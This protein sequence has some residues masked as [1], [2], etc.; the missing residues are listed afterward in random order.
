MTNYTNV[1][2][3][4]LKT[5][6]ELTSDYQLA[7]LLDVGTSRISNY[8]NGR[9]VLDWELAFKIADLLELDDQDV[10]YGLLD[11]KTVNPRL[12]NALQSRT[13]A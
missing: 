3:D 9:S 1:L 13:P 5:Q 4:Q 12:I 8:R 7:K 10:V 6:L 11:E 2:L